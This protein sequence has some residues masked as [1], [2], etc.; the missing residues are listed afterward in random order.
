MKHINYILKTIMAGATAASIMFTP[1]VSYAENSFTMTKTFTTNDQNATGRE[2]FDSVYDKDG[3]T[4]NLT[5]I[6]TNVVKIENVEGDTFIQET[7]GS[8]DIN[9]MVEPPA[10][11]TKDGVTYQLQSKNLKE[12][13]QENMTKYVERIIP[14]YGVE[15]TNEV[16]SLAE[17]VETDALGNEISQYMPLIDVTVEKEGWDSSFEFPIKITDYD[18]DIFMLNG[19]EIHKGDDLMDYADAFLEYLG[20]T[21][22]FYR[23]TSIEWD[24]DE[25]RS[26]G[27]VCRNAIA[28]GDKYLKDITA[29]YGGDMVI[30]A[31]TEYYYECVYV[32]P[33]K[34]ESTLYTIEAVGTYTEAQKETKP[35]QESEE[36][37]TEETEQEIEPLIP[38][39]PSKGIIQRVIGWIAQNPIA[40]LGIGTIA[41]VGVGTLILF[42]LAKKRKK[43]DKEDYEVVD[44]DKDKDKK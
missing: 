18:A 8:F 12:R 20:L 40:A 9:N 13:S 21:K 28:K 44:L 10:T 36:E 2:Y 35:T 26:G 41:V 42:I 24:G 32:N 15:N 22:E 14:F 5:D 6:K 39:T 7:E 17:V 25:Y 37:T 1:M 11:T 34:T 19:H 3:V 16:P 27:S 30:G 31:G 4:Y 23:I 38:P 43:D 33:N 29:R